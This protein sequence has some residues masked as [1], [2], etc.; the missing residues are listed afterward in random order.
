MA[1]DLSDP[2][3]I[4]TS[5]LEF[6][7]RSEEER[8]EAFAVLRRDAPAMAMPPLEP[9]LAVIAQENPTGACVLHPAPGVQPLGQS[10]RLRRPA[11]Q[12][13]AVA[14]SHVTSVSSHST[15]LEPS[16]EQKSPGPHATA[17][18]IESPLTPAMHFAPAPHSASAAQCTP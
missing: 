9:E 13:T 7:E 10:R 6:W 17:Q 11:L 5:S 15:Q 18:Q 3:S 12:V 16:P 2:A 4:N 14:P 1:L 8:D